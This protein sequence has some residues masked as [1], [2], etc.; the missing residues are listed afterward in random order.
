M[1]PI[2]RWAEANTQN[3]RLRNIG[4]LKKEFVVNA[5]HELIRCLSQSMAAASGLPRFTLVKSRETRLPGLWEIEVVL[6]EQ[7]KSIQRQFV[8]TS[9]LAPSR[10][11]D[12]LASPPQKHSLTDLL[13]SSSPPMVSPSA[14]MATKTSSAKR[15][16][17][18][19]QPSKL[20]SEGKSAPVV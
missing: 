3:E 16:R 1:E 12:M 8:S 4:W 18:E 10:S 5:T 2:R 11:A 19:S 20:I 15:R 13:K 6:G 17:M 9:S 7:A 14:Y